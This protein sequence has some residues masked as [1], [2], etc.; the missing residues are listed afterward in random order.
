MATGGLQAKQYQQALLPY[1]DHLVLLEPACVET[2]IDQP[3]KLRQFRA[4]YIDVEFRLF[5]PYFNDQYLLEELGAPSRELEQF[6]F[7]PNVHSEISESGIVTML[8]KWALNAY[9]PK[10]STLSMGTIQDRN[11]RSADNLPE[12]ISG[13]RYTLTITESQNGGRESPSR[14]ADRSIQMKFDYRQ[15]FGELFIRQVTANYAFAKNDRDRFENDEKRFEHYRNSYGVYC[16]KRR[17]GQ[18]LRRFP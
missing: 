14:L 2:P 5:I 7:C 3:L 1:V 6:Y 10:L 9:K 8:I 11:C 13:D 12:T 17:Y 15:L 18:N 16:P 4:L